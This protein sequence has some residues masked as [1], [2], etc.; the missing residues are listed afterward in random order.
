[1]LEPK[2]KRELPPFTRAEFD[3]R[4]ERARRLMAR[5]KLDGMLLTSMVNQEY[6]AGF[7][8]QFPV[9]SPSRP[10]YFYFPRTGAPV[11][12]V[13]AVGENAWR[14]SSWVEE[15]RTW[16]SPRP[17]N[18]GLD[19]LR[20]LIAGTRRRYGRIG[21]EMGPETRL[22][23]PV[24]DLLRLRDM[25]RPHEMVD[26]E[27]VMRELRFIKSKAEIARVRRACRIACAAFDLLPDFVESGDSEKVIMRKMKT[28]CT[29][30]GADDTSYMMTRTGPQ[31]LPSWVAGPYDHVPRKGDVL[32]I[33]TGC[34]YDGYSSDLN[35]NFSFGKPSDAVRRAHDKLW[36]ATRAGI[37]AAV[38]GATAEQVFLAQ[39][40]ILN[41]G[42]S[43][44]GFKRMGRFGHGLGK[45]LTE[46]PSNKLGDK[47]KL[48]P[49]MVLT[50]EPGLLMDNGM[51]VAH[52][53]N[54]A[55]TEDGNRLLT[56]RAPREIPTIRV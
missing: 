22:G 49:G 56:M 37:E 21:V 26:C 12:V 50:V 18:E 30:L 44:D 9:S 14:T 33:D 6:L 5:A 52:E 27:P 2:Y 54:L 10:W 7:Q 35:R 4:A 1:M 11:G 8:C 3:G 13:P 28:R 41:E 15:V 40:A 23:M 55:I 48:R 31:G 53:E 46:P 19:I 51:M 45:L 43:A 47:T 36:R 32:A 38:P 29:A 20:D 24:E 42:G 25:I 17:E 39:A 34:K 16:P